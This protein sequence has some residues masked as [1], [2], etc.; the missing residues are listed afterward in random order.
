MPTTTLER[1][2]VGTRRIGYAV[3][4][5]VNTTLLYL[6]ND[7]PGWAA[8]PFLTADTALVVPLINLSIGVGIVINLAR[9]AYDPQWFVA[10]GDVVTTGIGLAALLRI[11][12]V[13]P[14]EFASGT[15]DWSLIVR[16]VLVF[17]IVGSVIGIVAGLVS[18]VRDIAVRAG[19][20]R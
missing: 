9:I 11:W 5:V 8:L 3:G 4:A 20:A 15:V 19:A 12:R 17:A 16:V 2:S 18:M 13:F 6:V 1:R 10:F 7:W 14:F